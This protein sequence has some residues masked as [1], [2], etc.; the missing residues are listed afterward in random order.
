VVAIAA[1]ALVL[2]A[3]ILLVDASQGILTGALRGAADIWACI[4]VQ[5]VCFWLICIPVCYLLAHPLGFGVAGLLWGLFV[6]LLAAALLLA[7]RFK[8]LAAREVRPF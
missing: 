3:W 6:G 5:F 8:A 7:W 1:P 2:A 4:T